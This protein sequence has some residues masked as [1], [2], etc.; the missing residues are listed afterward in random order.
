MHF[1]LHIRMLSFGQ[2]NADMWEGYSK[3]HASQILRKSDF[4]KKYVG[5]LDEQGLSRVCPKR[6]IDQDLRRQ[7]KAL[8]DF[9]TAGKYHADGFCKKPSKNGQ[10]KISI[11]SKKLK[12]GK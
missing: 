6:K 2:Q 7:V 1:P 11:F 8:Y 5:C 9:L 10:E 4:S 12:Q 3:I